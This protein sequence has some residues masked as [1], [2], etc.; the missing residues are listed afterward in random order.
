M[1][2]VS[3]GAMSDALLCLPGIKRNDIEDAVSRLITLRE[4]HYA[5]WQAVLTGIAQ[6]HGITNDE[7]LSN[8]NGGIW[9]ATE[10]VLRHN[11]PLDE[12]LSATALCFAGADRS[13]GMSIFDV[14]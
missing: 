12:I 9:R 14:P 11:V 13:A 5:A 6:R 4:P 2:K 7:L 1:A 8:F 10:M 3:N